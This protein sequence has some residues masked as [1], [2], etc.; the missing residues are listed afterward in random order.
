MPERVYSVLKFER[1]GV[2]WQDQMEES[3]LVS[4]LLVGLCLCT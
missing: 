3:Q 1:S 2:V 4:K